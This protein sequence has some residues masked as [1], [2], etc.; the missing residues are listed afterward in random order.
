MT[1]SLKNGGFILYD[2]KS[3]GKETE[4]G[5]NGAHDLF[6]D[7]MREMMGK[8][9]GKNDNGGGANQGKGSTP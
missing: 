2:G 4:Y 5:T 7:D 9:T 6:A 3:F 8:G 1:N